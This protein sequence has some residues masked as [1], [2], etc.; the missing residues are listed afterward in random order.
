MDTNLNKVLQV[1]KICINFGGIN[2]LKDISLSINKNKITCIIGPNGAGKTTFFNCITGFY[3]AT[4]GTITLH[5]NNKEILINKIISENFL[6]EDFLNYKK[7][8]TKLYY[9]L[10]G[11]SHL[12][13]RYGIARTFQNIRLFKDITV[14]EN[15]LIAQHN[16][17]NTNIIS[18]FF[19]TKSYKYQLNK[20]IHESYKWLKFFNI[21]K[22]ANHLAKDLSYGIQKKV[23]IA[24]AMCT[25]PILLC[26]DEPAAGLNNKETAELSEYL[27]KIKKEYNLTIALIEHDMDLVMK[28][29]DYIYVLDNGSLL[30]QGTP[31][32]IKK[33]PKVIS[34]Y[35]GVE[36]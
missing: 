15:L 27:Q 20:A 24:R 12:V 32:I 25:R 29:S 2:A 8:F 28:I 9:K 3:K 11:G 1:D 26:L 34:A 4:S 21:E 22:Y 33:D 7:T 19:N 17:L 35:L 10:F 16:F 23:E 30:T 13:N 14:V 18:G 36:Y 5:N 31:N 6:A